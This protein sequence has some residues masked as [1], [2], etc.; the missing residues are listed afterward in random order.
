M[1]Q[2]IDSGADVNG[3]DQVSAPYTRPLFVLNPCELYFV[4]T[5]LHVL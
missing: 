2:L 5:L 4:I 3:Q 1:Q